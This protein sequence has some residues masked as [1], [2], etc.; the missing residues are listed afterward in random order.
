M[1]CCILSAS[2][3]SLSSRSDVAIVLVTLSMELSYLQG[4]NERRQY[5]AGNS[6]RCYSA[7]RCVKLREAVCTC[8]HS[9]QG[10][11]QGEHRFKT[12]RR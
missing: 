4:R 9:A 8:R 5:L 7:L 1:L 11:L 2:L 6:K 3:R 12:C 10:F